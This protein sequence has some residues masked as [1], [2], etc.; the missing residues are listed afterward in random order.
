MRLEIRAR[1]MAR[2]D[3]GEY[4]DRRECGNVREEGK[5]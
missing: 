5:S 3:T 2:G 1:K 4:E